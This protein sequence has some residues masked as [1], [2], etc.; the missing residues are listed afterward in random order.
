M[1]INKQIIFNYWIIWNIL[2]VFR[3]IYF[4]AIPGLKPKLNIKPRKP[5]KLFDV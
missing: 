3:F 1:H 2:D 4:L 5:G